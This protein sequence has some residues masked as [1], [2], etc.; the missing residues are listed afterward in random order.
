MEYN[1]FL[2]VK[3]GAEDLAEAYAAVAKVLETVK[4][5]GEITKVE[6]SDKVPAKLTGHKPGCRWVPGSR[7]VCNCKDI[8]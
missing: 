1:L 3:L 8:M 2:N 7:T 6:V 4:G 5:L